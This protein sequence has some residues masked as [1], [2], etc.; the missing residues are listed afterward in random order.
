[1]TTVPA[2]NQEPADDEVAGVAWDLDP[3]V[4]G[5]GEEGVR[6]L[7]AQAAERADA[8][9]AA[10]A[11]KLATLDAPGLR[12]AMEQLA[13]LHELVGRA[14]SYASLRFAVDTADERIGALLQHVQERATAIQTTLLFFELEWATLDD[15]RAEELLAGEDNAFFAHY[16]R[17]ERRYRPYLLSE[18]EERILAEKG[19]SGAGAWTRLFAELMS[20]LEVR[21][22]SAPEPVTLEQALA[23]LSGPDRD[24]RRGA[25]EAVTE[26]LRPGLRTR[27]FIFNTLL[28]DKAVDDRL[29]TYPNWLTAR[30]LAN[31][32]SDESVQALV[33]AVRGRYDVPQ[34]W[35]RLKARLLGVERLADYDRAATVADTDERF[36]WREARELVLDAYD[37]FTPELGA[38]ARRFFDER[39]I[40]APVRPG[41]RGGAFCSY[42]VPSAHPYVLLNYTARRRDVLTL[43]HE[44]GHGVHAALAAPQGVFHQ[45]TPLTLAETASVFG[46]TLVFGRLLE[47]ASTPA[48][49]LSLLSESIEGAIATVFRQTAMHTFEETIHTARREEGELGIDRFGE[50]WAASQ[51]ELFGDAVEVTEGYRT[52]WSYIPHFINS[53]GYVYAY[54]YGQ[55][56]A[57]SVYGRYRQEGASFVPDYLRMLSA[58]GSMA[59]EELGRLVGLDLTDPGFWDAGLAL[60][61]DQL[62]A[63]EQAAAEAGRA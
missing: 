6:A 1:M 16:L 58:G 35:Y 26:A 43:A 38:L 51:E 2:T 50:L 49:R 21:L 62:T 46:E 28:H 32:A 7:L 61:D 25:A 8:F 59:P 33:T 4:D 63:A 19:I 11:G 42:T 37:S 39:W 22:P 20:S 15:A 30:N 23:L 3:L 41:K 9:A 55:L 29:R 45:G 54:A 56:L 34:R 57:L 5:R 31:E 17:T 27:A 14:G 13:A 12:T 53:P 10:Y 44:L 18:P 47:S 60:V 48:S 52:W 24:E 40:D 36:T